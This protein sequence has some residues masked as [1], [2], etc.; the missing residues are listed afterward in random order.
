MFKI[1]AVDDDK[2]VLE[3]VCKCTR[4]FFEKQEHPIKLD[5]FFTSRDLMDGLKE[6]DS[7]HIYLL[8][9]EM[10]EIS[11]IELAEQIRLQ[12]NSAYIIFITSH[13]S[14]AIMGYELKIY[15]YVSK[16]DIDKKL[17]EALKAIVQEVQVQD[18]KRY[19]IRTNN[20]IEKLFYKNILYLYKDGKNAVFVTFDGESYVRKALQMVDKELNSDDFIYIDRGY[21]VNIYHVMRFQNH[22][23]LL[24]NGTLLKVSRTHKQKLQEKILEFWGG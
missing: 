1:A 5:L 21:I 7:Y 24:R 9:I 8:D 22:E 3:Q 18:G 6:E 15:R 20:R 10:P 19:I 11:G 2:V 14:Y 13:S 4:E 12:D 17:P 16:D 23:L